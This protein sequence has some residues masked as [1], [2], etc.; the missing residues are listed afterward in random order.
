MQLSDS[1]FKNIFPFE[2][3]RNNQRDIIE[4]IISAFKNGKRYVILNAPTGIGKSAIGYSVARYYG[5]ATIL[6]S[7][8]VLQEQYYK[9]FM[10]PFV[11]GR[12]NYICQKNNTITCEIGM[13]F[14]DPRRMCKDNKG[15]VTCPYQIAKEKCLNAPYSN[16]NYS[17]YLS[18][19]GNDNDKN[20]VPAGFKDLLICDECHNIES[21]LLKQYSVKID[22]L[23]LKFVGCNDV[24]I[25][26]RRMSDNEKCRW[27]TN[28]MYESI[29]ANFLYLASQLKSLTKLKSTK[30]Y[31]KL[32][33]KY[34]TVGTMANAI[35]MIKEMY[36]NGETIVVTHDNVEEKIEFKMLH[37]NKLFEKCMGKRAKHFLFMSATVLNYKSYIKDIG[38]NENLVEYIECDSV[39]PVE[40]RLIHFSPVGSMSRKNKD[41]TMPEMI[42]KI[43][44]ILKENKNV[45][46][47]IHTVSYDVAEKIMNGLTFS[48]Q[49]ER[50]LMPRGMTKNLTLDVFYNSDKPYVLLSPALMEG[51]DLKDDLSRLCII[52]KVPYA[53]L[54]DKWTEMRMKES[55]EWYTTATCMNLIQMTGR[56]IRSE[57]DFAKT[58][59]LDKDFMTLAKNSINIIPKWWQ[60]AVILD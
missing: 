53:N 20:E 54:G 45:K 59:I 46:G 7:Q 58:Y 34:S 14:R 2:S 44:K 48:D 9:D 60:E 33:T 13:C 38:L 24:K 37:C 41:A 15:C 8:K 43:D 11:L 5:N 6:T 52:C 27:L 26:D 40:N 42:K 21:E 10:I 31:K 17:Y 19:F 22:D 32:A 51:I 1:E 35:G 36:E 50:L 4:R 18:F 29:R 16:L 28:E 12:A 23:T 25:P 55:N 30:E 3:P 47:I 49:S 39:F 56:S 57:T